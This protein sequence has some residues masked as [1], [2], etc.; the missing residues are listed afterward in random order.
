MP[1]K[2]LFRTKRFLLL[3]AISFFCLTLVHD[4]KCQSIIPQPAEITGNVNLSAQHLQYIFSNQKE[5]Q[6]DIQVFNSLLKKL[7]YPILIQK[8]SKT[9]AVECVIDKTM[10][11]EEYQIEALPNSSIK[12][13]GKSSGVFYGLMSLLQMIHSSNQQASAENISLIQDKPAFGWRGMHLDVSRHFFSVDFIKKYLDIL[14][15]HKM[16]TFH[17]HLTDDQ[18]WRIEIKKYPLL[19]QLGSKRHESILEKNFT[20]YIGDGKPVEGF[21]TQE[22]VKE[23]VNYAAERHITVVPE[24]EMPGHAQ[25]ALSAYPQ[26]SCAGG[27][28]EV[29]T[30]WGV[31]EDVFC[32]KDSTFTFLKNI[33]DEVMKLFPSKYIH[34][35]GD[36]VPKERWKKCATCQANMA[37]YNLK[38]EHELQSYF[39]KKIDEYLTK[40]GRNCIGWDE[41][42]EGGLAPNAAVMSWRGEEGG[43]EA[44]K[45]LHNVVMTPGSHCYF[46]HYQGNRNTEPL[47]IGGYT[48]IEKVYSYNPIPDKLNL[49]Q[50]KYIMGAQANVWTEYISTNEHVEYMVMPRM[51]ALAEVL[52]TGKA[53]PGF[54]DFKRRLKRHFSFLD[55]FGIYY[56]RSIYDV[57]YQTE[58]MQNG[59][60]VKLHSNYQDGTIYFA[61][62]GLS[63][64]TNSSVYDPNSPILIDESTTLKAQY[65]EH[66]EPA[67]N[68]LTLDILIHKALGKK[69]EATPAPSIYYNKGGMKKAVDGFAGKMPKYNDDWL[70]WYGESPSILIDLGEDQLLNSVSLFLMKDEPNG[71]FLPKD[72]EIKV[73]TSMD[74]FILAKQMDN[75]EILQSFVPNAAID[76]RFDNM[77]LGRYIKINLKHATKQDENNTQKPWLFVSEISVD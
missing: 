17:W 10:K 49:E 30:K 71:I 47:A 43:I 54:D 35:G 48:P 18:G 45:Q 51:C 57:Y 72:I 19:T 1:Y 40:K 39:I 76:L 36:E 8:E 66:G 3:L 24:I 14:A 5:L 15:M 13:K 55:K 77:I 74:N 31:S 56:A 70:A 61:L 26:Y 58:T 9:H 32:T 62:D 52:W 29:L 12:I 33:L 65:F 60:Q 59:L 2:P 27:P 28:L 67:G 6:R 38:N 42:L 75:M 7:G 11:E 16:N 22:Q 53:K 69:I 20:P 63:P 68:E 73:G 50:A 21:Y 41:I 46:D 4:G 25:A 44:S 64:D 37:K 23:I 34:I